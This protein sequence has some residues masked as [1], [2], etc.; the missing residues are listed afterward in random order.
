MDQKLNNKEEDESFYFPHTHNFSALNY[1]KVHEETEEDRKKKE[2]MI[3]VHKYPYL[4]HGMY[5]LL[6]KAALLDED[7]DKEYE[8]LKNWQYFM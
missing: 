5:E 4:F 7:L 3:K 2:I 6:C 1:I 8:D